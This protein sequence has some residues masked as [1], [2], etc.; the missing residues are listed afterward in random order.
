M[1]F[2]FK[3]LLEGYQRVELKCRLQSIFDL[4]SRYVDDAIFMAQQ[5]IDNA[6]S[7]GQN[8]RKIIFGGRKLFERFQSKRLT[9]EEH[10]R[11]KAEW[12]ERRQGNLMSRGD[13]SKGGNLNL[14][15]VRRDDG[16]YL[17]VNV[18]NRQWLMFK[19]KTAHK[20]WQTFAEVIKRR[21][22]YCVQIK[23][24]Q[25]RYHVLIS[26][27]EPQ[28]AA[29]IGFDKGAIGVDINAFPSR[30]AWAEIDCTGNL[31]SYGVINAPQLWNG[32]ANQRNYWCWQIA[33]R[34]IRIAKSKEKGIV[35]EDLKIQDKGIRGD[36]S[37]RKS[38]RIRHQFTYR[39]LISC[40]KRAAA[41][42]GVAIREVNPAYT[43]VIGSLKYAPQLSLS[44]DVAAAW[45]IA[46]R[47]L[48]FCERIPK[49]YKA[50]LKSLQPESGTVEESTDGRNSLTAGAAKS[51]LYNPWR[52]LKVAVLTALSPGRRVPRCLSPL[53][54]FL[55][56][57]TWGEPT[58]GREV[59]LPG[60]G[61]MGGQIPPAG[62]GRP[63]DG[64]P[65]QIARPRASCA[66]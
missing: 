36:W 12:K 64:G 61:P 47:G 7:R 19:M 10:E 1:R 16:Y 26:F 42:H 43:S 34:L 48:G 50:L 54:R 56:Q 8:P 59:L 39:K 25:G 33:H 45:V 31:S 14:R 57:G 38:R 2:A 6:K 13:R 27:K 52:A 49:N 3:R 55:I 15:V 44:K 9:P 35:I 65:G 21:E 24:R 58:K 5:I 63:E 11:L 40:L 53:K 23:K 62:S 4:N 46:R 30:I 60:A 32:R 17:R 29:A 41:R 37:G 51:H 20:R 22:P 18:G 28:P 66:L